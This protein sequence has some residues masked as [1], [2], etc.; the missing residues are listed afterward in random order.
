VVKR[1]L[2]PALNYQE[3]S[4]F[5]LPNDLSAPRDSELK[6]N[7][8]HAIADLLRRFIPFFGGKTLALF[9]ANSRR[10]YVFQHIADTIAE[11]GF[12]VFCQAQGS[13]QHLL[14]KFRTMK[15]SSLLGSRSL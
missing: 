12:P 6:R 9:T 1:E 5:M 4:L 11:R 13:L 3:Q 8:P 2:P 15:E 7:F 10:D 14:E